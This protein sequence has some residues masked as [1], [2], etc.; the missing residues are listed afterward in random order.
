MLLDKFDEILSK[1]IEKAIG[2]GNIEE[3][4][5]LLDQMR[6]LLETTDAKFK[7]IGNKP[8][9]KKVKKKKLSKEEQPTTR[10]IKPQKKKAVAH[11]FQNNFI[12]EGTEHKDEDNITP[13][14]PPVERRPGVK[15]QPKVSVTC[16]VCGKTSKIEASRL[17]GTGVFEEGEFKGQSCFRCD[18]CCERRE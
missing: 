18:K 5:A 15:K 14:Y 1:N 7:A 2:K 13:Y 11:K 17:E 3:A 4:K 8:K 12:D 16:W 9:R 6:Q 10:E